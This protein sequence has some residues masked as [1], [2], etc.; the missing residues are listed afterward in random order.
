[1]S[2]DTDLAGIE[3]I[4]ASSQNSPWGGAMI[5]NSLMI[6]HSELRDIDS[7]QLLIGSNT[8]CTQN[9]VLLPFSTRLTVSN[10]TFVNFEEQGCQAF[11]TCAHC[12]PFDGAAM[13]RT[14]Q[15]AFENVANKVSF[16]FIHSTL[17][18][19]QDGTLVGGV[20]STA[21]ASILPSS[22]YLDPA[23]CQVVPAFSVGGVNGSVCRTMKFAKIA[24]NEMKPSSIDEKDAY[25]TNK[26]GSDV[27]TWRKKSK[28]GLTLGYTTF[29]PVNEEVTLSF[30]NSTQ[31]TNISFNMRIFEM[32]PQQSAHIKLKFNQLPDHFSTGDV[33]RNNTYV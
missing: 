26:H 6:G 11:G 31:F 22:G 20:G 25:L 15:L 5:S 29:L 8:R 18:T 21:N 13:V 23:D 7:Y 9:G 14:R 4:D 27:V 24:W 2:L 16:G 19:D 17:I 1:M 12:K 30:Q 33:K 28:S 32:P 10:T 3:Y